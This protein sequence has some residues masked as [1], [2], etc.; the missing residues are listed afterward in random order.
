MSNDAQILCLGEQIVGAA[1]ARILVEEW[2]SSEFAG[3]RSGPKVA[4]MAEID[5]RYRRMP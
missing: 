5:K 1:L 4:K 3:G 2:I